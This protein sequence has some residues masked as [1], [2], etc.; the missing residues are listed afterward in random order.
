MKKVTLFGSALAVALLSGPAM[1]ADFHAL[2]VLQ[3]APAALQDS[4]LATTEGGADCSSAGGSTATNGGSG[5][6]CL[7][8]DIG[9]AQGASFA[10]ANDAPVTGANFLQVT[11]GL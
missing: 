9:G 4:E 1:A 7:V 5:G 8:G 6:V 11:G 3:T 2:T 10:V